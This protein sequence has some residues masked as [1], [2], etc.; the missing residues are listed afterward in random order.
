MFNIECVYDG[1][2][3]LGEGPVWNLQ[4]QK[5][6][7]TDIL[8]HEIWVYDPILRLSK[9]FWKGSLQVGGFAFNHEGAIIL[10]TD[11]GIYKLDINS[12]EPSHEE[13]K[14]LFDIPLSENERFND[15]TVDP[16][17]RIFAGT[18]S[19]P[20][21]TN[22]KLY[23][24]EK[25]KKPSVVLSNLYCSNGMTFSMDERYFFHTDSTLHR[26][27]KYAY[28]RTNGEISSPSIYFQGTGDMGL[29]DGITLDSEDHIWAAFWGGSCVRRLDPKGKI[30][31]EIPLPVKQPSSVIF[32]GRNL[33]ELYITSA[34]EN[35]D[36]IITGYCKDGTFIGGPMYKY[37][38]GVTGRPEW[39]ADI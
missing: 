27:T 12:E 10:C 4:Q 6:F 1:I 19:R 20:D 21:F 7:W 13:P 15:I 38:Q 35:A 39:L 2:C 26:I 5:L 8:K 30:V 31:A 17:G 33:D 23:R 34:C 36:D 25:G 14:L 18:I 37:H 29:P 11:K 28:D 22:G 3:H 16:K 32:G 24:M 9:I